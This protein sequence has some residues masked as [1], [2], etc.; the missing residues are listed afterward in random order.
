MSSITFG[1]TLYR[2][3][4][5]KAKVRVTAR[6]RRIGQRDGD[7]VFFS[8]EP[9]LNVAG[10][11]EQLFVVVSVMNVGRRRM[12]WLGYGGRF[13]KPVNGKNGFTVSA[14]FLPKILE[15]QEAFDEFTELDAQFTN[16]NVK[17]L[18]IW[19]GAG[20]EWHVSRKELKKLIS[21]AKKYAQV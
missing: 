19:D 20:G 12:R 1:W 10:A 4:R 14:R 2:D 13:R 5:D 3:L 21:D 17:K 18:Y 7:G 11:S 6:V 9:G 16:G 8:I 15:E